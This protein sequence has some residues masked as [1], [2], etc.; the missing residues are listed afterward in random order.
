MN[1]H[2]SNAALNLAFTMDLEEAAKILTHHQRAE[3][4]DLG[5]APLGPEPLQLAAARIV[6]EW[7]DLFGACPAIH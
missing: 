4:P 7:V 3:G 6:C 2:H 5:R 1:A